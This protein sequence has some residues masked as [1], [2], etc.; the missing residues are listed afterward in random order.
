[1]DK[2]LVI[3]TG[4]TIGAKSGSTITLDQPL[5]IVDLYKDEHPAEFVCDAPFNIFSEHSNIQFL[6][7]LCNYLEKVDFPAYTGIIL[8]HGSDTL[9]FTGALLAQLFQDKS[10]VLVGADKPLDHAKSNG[11]ANFDIAVKHLLRSK[12][13]GVFISYDGLHPAWKTTS[14]DCTDI[15]READVPFIP[16]DSPAFHPKNI[17]VITPHPGIEYSSFNLNK[18]DAVLHAMYHSATVPA[19]AQ[20][21]ARQCK[22]KG[23]PFYFVTHHAK[24][25][26][27]TTEKLTNILFSSTMENAFAKLLLTNE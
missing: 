24:A 23:I 19:Q 17:L 7:D 21:F 16:I 4:G 20:K 1:M 26:Y 12:N 5:K 9:A 13:A 2:I 27:K 18:T 3:G 6:H 10:I 15:F 14:A 8:L 11:P 22:E 25:N